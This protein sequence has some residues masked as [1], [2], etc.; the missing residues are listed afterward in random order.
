[1]FSTAASSARVIV[2][3]V[4]RLEICEFFKLANTPKLFVALVALTVI[5]FSPP[6]K[7][8][9]STKSALGEW[10]SKLISQISSK[11]LLSGSS[12]APS[13]KYLL[14]VSA[15]PIFIGSSRVPVPVPSGFA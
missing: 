15:E 8:I 12:V 14:K 13:A 4:L 7:L 11:Y 9:F 3:A 1:M 10:F 6:S 5:V 2:P